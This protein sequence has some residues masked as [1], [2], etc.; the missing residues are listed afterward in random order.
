MGLLSP[1]PG[2]LFW[3]VIVF[4]IVFIILAKYAFPV[5]NS[6]VDKRKQYIDSSLEAAHQANEKLE[7]VKAECETLLARA[8]QEQTAILKAAAASRDKIVAE[9]K[10][11]ARSEAKKALDETRHQIEAEKESAINDIRRMVAVLSVNVA[12]KILRSKLSS[13][14]DQLALIERLID[15]VKSNNQVEQ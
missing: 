6:M 1:D 10:D 12:E 14:K 7:Q 2:T 13:D 9:A 11:R 8:H 3:M 5:I 4:A 15:E